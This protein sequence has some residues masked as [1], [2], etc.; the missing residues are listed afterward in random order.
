MKPS[1]LQELLELY[2]NDTAAKWLKSPHPML[3]GKTPFD[4]IRDG[5]WQEVAD[6]VHRLASGA[7]L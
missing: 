6:I 5:Q 3:N 2:D 1:W 4:A 7:Y